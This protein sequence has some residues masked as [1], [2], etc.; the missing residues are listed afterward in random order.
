VTWLLQLYGQFNYDYL[1]AIGDCVKIPIRIDDDAT[2]G[3]V[4][5]VDPLHYASRHSRHKSAPVSCVDFAIMVITAYGGATTQAR[6]TYPLRDAFSSILV[7]MTARPG[8]H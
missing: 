2:A 6:A 8:V 3:L 4:V 5:T 1:C 7:G